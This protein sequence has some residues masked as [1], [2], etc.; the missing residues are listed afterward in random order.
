M[1]LDRDFVPGAEMLRARSVVASVWLVALVLFVRPSSAAACSPLFDPPTIADVGPA[2]V[3]VVG[4]TGERVAGG[5]LFHVTRWFNGQGAV[6]PI[7]IAFKEGPSSGDCGLP[8]GCRCA[9][10][11]R[12][13]HGGRE[14]VG[15]PQIRSRPILIVTSGGRTSRRRPSGSGQGSCPRRGAAARVSRARTPGDAVYRVRPRTPGAVVAFVVVAVV[16]L[17]V[18]VVLL[19]RRRSRA[20]TVR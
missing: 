5:R 15:E 20:S 8:D 16:S 4:M 18:G 17:F 14:A 1:A 7:V 2:Q 19:A 12:A 6:T 3:V 9:A 11:H 10:D 13:R